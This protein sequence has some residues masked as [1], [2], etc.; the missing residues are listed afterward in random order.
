MNEYY[1]GL[2]SGTSLD[3]VDAVLMDFAAPIEQRCIHHVSLPYNQQTREQILALQDIGTDELNRS[4]L[5]ANQLSLF[6]IQ[7]VNELLAQTGLNVDQVCAIGCHGQTIRH[8]PH[9]NFTIQLANLAL[10]A[11]QT[12]IDVVGD[13]RSRDIAAA[14]Q[15]APLVP[16]FHQY[17]FGHP[18]ENRVVLNIGGIANISI[19]AQSGQLSGFDTG[20]GNML[21]DAWTRQNWQK[22]YDDGGRFA[23]RGQV[24]DDLLSQ[25]LSDEYFSRAHPK[26]TGRDHFNLY[27]LTKSLQGGENPYDVQATLLALTT[28]SI[29]QAISLAAPETQRIIVCGGGVHNKIL[30]DL[31]QAQL[32]LVQFEV[33]DGYGINSQCVEGAAFAW[34]AR[35]FTHRIPAN[36]PEVTGASGLRILGALYPA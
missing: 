29:T 1:I 33:V 22:D 28:T 27:W 13:F 9:L 6:Y 24:L 21:M 34:L 16:A 5:L 15:G 19:L 26:S 36:V 7:A 2:M 25:M 35:Q 30:F 3:A 31:L 12:G 17:L 4:N 14:G 8:A 11:E 32:P 18:K 10:I 20:P 23:A